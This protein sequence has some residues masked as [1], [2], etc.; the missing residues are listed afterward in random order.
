[1]RSIASYELVI[2][3]TTINGI[4]PDKDQPRQGGGLSG[5]VAWKL[6]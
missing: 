5:K 2:L 3:L 1:M 6:L 4:S